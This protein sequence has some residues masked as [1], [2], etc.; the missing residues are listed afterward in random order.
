MF[1]ADSGIS[2][3]DFDPNGEYAATLDRSG[4]CLISTINTDEF[5]VYQK[6][7]MYSDDLSGNPVLN[8]KTTIHSFTFN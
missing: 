1:I 4:N 6:L 5:K 2:G 8:I 3:F 7:K